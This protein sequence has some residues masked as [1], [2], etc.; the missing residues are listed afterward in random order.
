MLYMAMHSIPN[1]ATEVFVERLNR[2]R[3]T[4]HETTGTVDSIAEQELHKFTVKTLLL[5]GATCGLGVAMSLV[6]LNKVVID[7]LWKDRHAETLIKFLK[8]S[9]AEPPD[10]EH[11]EG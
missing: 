7:F 1:I 6:A 2:N 3:I 8:A 4:I 9:T 10:N 11:N 5:Y